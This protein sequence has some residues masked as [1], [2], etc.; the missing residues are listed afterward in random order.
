MSWLQR[1]WIGGLLAAVASAILSAVCFNH[2]MIPHQLLS[3]GMS[4]LSMLIGYI[5]GWDISLLYLALNAPVLVWGLISVGR[6]F[7]ALSIVSVVLTSLFMK[8]LPTVPVAEDLI[9]NAVTGGVLLGIGTGL[10]MRS[11]GSTGG[12]DILG[13]I[14]TRKRDFPLG[15]ILFV[16]NG[17]VIVALGYYEQ[18]WDL[19]LYSLLSIYITVKIVDAIHIRHVKVTVFVVTRKK[20][21]LLKKMSKLQRGVTVLQT[22]GAFTKQPQHMLMT[23]I[24]RYELND[25]QAIVRQWDPQAFVNIVETTGVM[26]LFRRS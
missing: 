7:I 15:A 26:G 13:Y 18:N 8:W 22:E 2:F 25:V 6:K 17:I 19:A 23:V 9:L 16:L 5:T 11:G 21:I 4:G 24:T 3:G 10:A 14:I 1:S 12:F 20:D